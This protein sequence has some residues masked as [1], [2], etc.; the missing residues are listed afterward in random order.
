MSATRTTPAVVFP[1][2]EKIEI[3]EVQVPPLGPKDVLVRT[4]VT[5]IS[6]GTEL[7]VL[8]GTFPNQEFPCVVGYQN[9]GVVVEIGAEVS[10]LAVGTRVVVQGGTLP[11][12]YHTGCGVAH[13]G[14]LVTHSE[15]CIPLSEGVP[16]TTAVYGIMAAVGLLGY[17]FCHEPTG[18]VVAVTGQG[19]IGQFAAQIFR[20]T[21]NRVYA[22]DIKP[23]R[24]E[25][26]G[27][28]SA[29]VA[30]CGPIDAFDRCLRQDYP[31]GADILVETTGNTKVF[32]QSLCLVRKRGLVCVQ[33]HYPYD[34]CFSFRVP[35][36]KMVTMVFP[37][38]WG[39]TPNLK[40]VEEMMQ[41]GELTVEP[42]ITHR[43]PYT[44]APRIYKALL[45]GDPE[46][47]GVVFIWNADTIYLGFANPTP[48]CGT[49]PA[50]A[51]PG[52]RGSCSSAPRRP[53]GRGFA[54]CG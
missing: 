27:K 33:G 31:D 47:L 44:E 22:S 17:Q 49:A 51:P 6:V 39:G 42:L 24:A 35:H 38:A 32:D 25:L 10:G 34:L 18:Q 37:C 45:A 23:L 53:S 54:S 7:M 9:V 16:D 40:L 30:F 21:G 13:I 1:K 36:W 19:L 26:S 5:A 20:R 14:H 48:A 3:R 46:V 28:Y 4:S 15:S 12:G 8:R 50:P 43:L 11:P 2:A 41:R 52:W 29:D